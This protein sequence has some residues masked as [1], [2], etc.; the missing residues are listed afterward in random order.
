MNIA[1]ELDILLN[2]PNVLMPR[3]YGFDGVRELVKA[4]RQQTIDE[5]LKKR[6]KDKRFKDGDVRNASDYGFNS[7]LKSWTDEINKIKWKH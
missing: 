4:V 2:Q 1:N 7:A 5:V 3:V 6:P